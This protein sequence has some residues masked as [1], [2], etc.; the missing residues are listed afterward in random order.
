MEH[1]DRGR[2][3]LTFRRHAGFTL[4]E[5]VV[6][7]AIIATVGAIMIPVTYH[8]FQVTR[9]EALVSEMENIQTGIQLFQRDVG[10]Y[11]Y[12]IDYLTTLFDP[13]PSG[14]RDV[15][16]AVISA[17]NQAKYRGPYLSKPI[18]AIDPLNSPA[19]DYA[20]VASGDS[21]LTLLAAGTL[22]TGRYLQ[23]TLKGPSQAITM[24]MDSVA[25]GIV[26]STAGRLRYVTPT[27]PEG[28]VLTWVVPIGP[29]D[30]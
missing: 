13:S 20:K 1:S 3:L 16:T 29:N 12:R 10:R 7:V 30:C 6:A 18:Q 24:L 26:S 8:R 25:D 23:I 4:I 5:M 27:T 11:P 17:A 9:A 19:N 15:C 28:N 21:V 14:I 22:G 2:R